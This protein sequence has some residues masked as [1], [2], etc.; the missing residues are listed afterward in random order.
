MRRYKYLYKHIVWCIYLYY[1]TLVW[2]PHTGQCKVLITPK[3]SF[4]TLIDHIYGR[5]PHDIEYD[6]WQEQLWVYYHNPLQLNIASREELRTLGIL[7]EE[8]VD[9]FF[10]HIAKHGPLIDIHELQ[11]ISGFDLTTINLLHPFVH[12][13]PASEGKSP[14]IRDRNIILRCERAL[15]TKRGYKYN[16]KNGK[17]PYVGDPNKFFMHIYIDH[18]TYG[19]FSLATKKGDGEAFI[20]APSSHRYGASL[21]RFHWALKEKKYFKKLI[22]G[23]YAVGYGQGVVLNAGFCTNKSNDV[24]SI[25]RTH[26]RGIRPHKT[27]GIAAFRGVGA[28]WQWDALTFTGYYSNLNLDGTCKGHI[29]MSNVSRGSTYR[30]QNEIQRKGK[31]NEQVVGGTL[32]YTGKH[33]TLGINVLGTGYNK[34]IKPKI[35]GDQVFCFTGQH[36]ANGSIFHSYLWRNMH[37]FGEHALT[38]KGDMGHVGGVMTS[39]SQYIDFSLLGRYYS[40]HFYSPYGKSFRERSTANNN[41]Y[42]GYFA[43]RLQPHR[44][45]ALCAYYDRFAALKPLHTLH[46]G[47]SWLTKVT[48]QP[49]KA[50][51]WHLQYKMIA[52]P[53]SA[54]SE[55][56][57]NMRDK[58]Q[59]K[60]RYQHAFNKCV[61]IKSELQYNYHAHKRTKNSGYAVVQDVVIRIKNLKLK[62][63]I[64]GFDIPHYHNAC[65]VYT[66]NVRHTGFNFRPHHGKGV[67]ASLLVGWQ[68]FSGIRLEGRYTLLYRLNSHVLGSG[69]ETSL[70]RCKQGLTVQLYFKP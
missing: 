41:E 19:E 66:P 64:I 25:M 31:I 18:L 2:R 30:T 15:V 58:Q 17:I 9:H 69:N 46:Q 44:S 63:Q 1:I 6:V 60:I 54:S 48:Y 16:E 65:Y 21:W 51:L 27:V 10:T 62:G 67:S 12:V 56:M 33:T 13:S 24:I 55:S 45:F 7:T 61:Q 39:L 3:Q 57:Y 14:L 53:T 68:L 22:I 23:D 40:P 11:S 38:H 36:H 20:W 42:G 59:L 8:Q 50:S 5:C 4:H 29:C 32:L 28:T 34:F 52:K 37:F 47:H 35:S 43:V 70:G 26:N 49:T